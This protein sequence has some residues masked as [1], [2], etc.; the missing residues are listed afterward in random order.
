MNKIIPISN[1]YFQNEHNSTR[2]DS[3]KRKA[4]DLEIYSTTTDNLLVLKRVG[5]IKEAPE[6]QAK[7]KH[8]A[9]LKLKQM[10]EI[11]KQGQRSLPESPKVNPTPAR[12]PQVKVKTIQEL[13]SPVENMRP[14]ST[15]DIASSKQLSPRP[16][17]KKIRIL[18]PA[19]VANMQKISHTQ[20]KKVPPIQVNKI[21]HTQVKQIR[22][23]SQN[24]LNE[25]NENSQ[26]PSPKTQAQQQSERKNELGQTQAKTVVSHPKILRQTPQQ[27]NIPTEVI[28]QEIKKMRAV[29]ETLRKESQAALSNMNFEVE[30]ILHPTLNY[31]VEQNTKFGNFVKDTMGYFDQLMMDLEKTA[32]IR[33]EVSSSS[34]FY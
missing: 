1:Y 16:Q 29:Q 23:L 21:P 24:Q 28:Q 25:I 22:V 2:N 7:K 18:T 26:S 5:E 6:C 33:T 27:V 19:E 9:Q 13:K 12:S 15:L 11:K 17:V 14:T 31:S 32:V 3:H 4:E 34:S 30:N 20:V 8:E 10:Q